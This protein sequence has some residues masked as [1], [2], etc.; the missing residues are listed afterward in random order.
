MEK[1]LSQEEKASLLQEYLIKQKILPSNAKISTIIN[2]L[3]QTTYFNIIVT[4]N[5]KK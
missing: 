4:F 5:W 2:D 1:K 3:D